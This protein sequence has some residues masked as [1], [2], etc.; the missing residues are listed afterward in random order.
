M[1]CSKLL[2]IFVGL[3]AL[4][5][6]HGYPIYPL[7]RQNTCS[8]NPKNAIYYPEN[9]DGITDPACRAA[10]KYVYNKANSAATAQYQFIQTNE[11]SI[12]I[13]NYADGY[14]AMTAAIKS[15][16]CSAG[17][18][19]APNDKSGMSIAAPWTVTSIS[20]PSVSTK[21][22]DIMFSYCATAPHN[23]SYWEFYVTKEGFDVSKNKITWNDVELITKID[24]VPTITTNDP[25]CSVTKAYNMTITLPARFSNSVLLSRWQRVDPVGEGFYSCSDF[26]FTTQD[27]SATTSTTG[28]YP[29]ITSSQSTTS[30]PTTSSTQTTSTTSTNQPTSTTSSTITDNNEGEGP[31]NSSSLKVSILLLF[32]I[33]SFALLF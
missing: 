32:I 1:Y 2:L 7:S 26:V 22:K 6:G 4:V 31:N 10:F 19:V 28:T 15:D 23:P 25:K 29:T 3:L 8:S 30:Q 9:G 21:S 33:V 14:S 12:N 5:N 18:T 20:V 13:P 17:Q 16:L 24:D 11:Y 27:G